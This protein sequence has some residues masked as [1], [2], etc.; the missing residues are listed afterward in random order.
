MVAWSYG[1]IRTTFQ[2]SELLLFCHKKSK[3]CH[4]V[5]NFISLESSCFTLGNQCRVFLFSILLSS[6]LDFCENES[7]KINEVNYGNSL[8]SF[9]PSVATLQVP[10]IS[11]GIDN[12]F[13]KNFFLMMRCLGRWS[14]NLI[15]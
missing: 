8:N 10:L 14:C 5:I 7:K 3:L 4:K 1:I 6:I 12:F 2:K 15:V 9:P 11:S 13:F